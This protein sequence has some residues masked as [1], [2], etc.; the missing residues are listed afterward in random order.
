MQP[1]HH[2]HTIPV[3]DGMDPMEAFTEIR[4]FGQLAEGKEVGE[5]GSGGSWA[6]VECPGPAA[7]CS[8]GRRSRWRFRWPRCDR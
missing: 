6:V 5:D 2:L 8:A 7:D 1:T 3:P 4:I